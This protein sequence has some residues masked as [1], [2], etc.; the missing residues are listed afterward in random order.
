MPAMVVL[1]D[2]NRMC[3]QSCPRRLMNGPDEVL[4]YSRQEEKRWYSPGYRR[5][6][7]MEQPRQMVGWHSVAKYLAV[8]CRSSSV[9][10]FSTIYLYP[11][12]VFGVWFR[13]CWQCR[14][15]ESWFGGTIPSRQARMGKSHKCP[16]LLRRKRGTQ[17]RLETMISCS[18]SHTRS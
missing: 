10:F 8:T 18:R 16:K 1:C 14:R 3:Q 15:T 7:I 6:G 11:L 5:A 4:N 12:S 13:G 2:A 9:P 17:E